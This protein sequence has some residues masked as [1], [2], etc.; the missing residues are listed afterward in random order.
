M[1][2]T[3][4]LLG[5]LLAATSVSAHS[6]FQDLWVAQT[7]KGASCVRMPLNNNPVTSVSGADIA[8][9][10]SPKVS[11]GTCAY[12]AGTQ[13]TVEMHAQPGDRSCSND[14]IGGNHDGPV[15]VYMAKVDN[16]L[17]ASGSSAKWFKVAAQGYLGNDKW[18]TDSLNT[19]CG[20][21]S[22]LI[23]SCIA[24]GDYLVRA[25]VIA[26]HVAGSIGGAQFYMSC[27]TI[28]VTGGGSTSPPTVSFPGAYSATDPGIHFDLYS[29]FTSYTIPGPAVFS[30]SG[31]NT[32]SVTIPTG[33]P[34][35]NPTPDVANP[36]AG[37]S[38]SSSSGG[39]SGSSSGGSA[40]LYGQCGGNDWTGPTTC[41]S[42]TCKAQSQYYSQCTP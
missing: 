17:T 36:A 33:S 5:S 40:A 30:C 39:S 20:R 14:A 9:N 6:T 18:A 26:L 2:F 19:N 11:S 35:A 16:A 42:G 41:A 23:P 38:T 7:D 28:T 12:T 3:S 8:C 25:E 29:A 15:I 24:P 21:F 27:Y 34:A 1:K 32:S 10:T 22:F 37:G 4:C 13:A 31:D